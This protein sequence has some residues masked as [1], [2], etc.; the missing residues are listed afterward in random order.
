MTGYKPSSLQKE[1]KKKKNT[2]C[3]TI[4]PR[5]QS[6]WV[7]IWVAST[8]SSSRFNP[9][10]QRD[11]PADSTLGQFQRGLLPS[12]QRFLLLLHPNYLLAPPRFAMIA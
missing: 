7:S 6:A 11:E 10:R 2:G 5:S 3:V 12:Y 8:L 9:F 4:V 1:T